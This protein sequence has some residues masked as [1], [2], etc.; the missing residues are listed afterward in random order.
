MRIFCRISSNRLVLQSHNF[1]KTKSKCEQHRNP[2]LNKFGDAIGGVLGA[3]CHDLWMNP[4]EVVKQRKQMKGSPYINKSYPHM[5][6]EIFRTEG[7]RAFYLSL[8][9]QLSMNATLGSTTPTRWKLTFAL[10]YSRT[11]PVLIVPFAFLQFGIY[12]IVKKHLNPRNEYSPGTNAVSGAVAGGVAAFIT[13]PLDV[14]KTVLN[15]QEN[16]T[17][18]NICNPC[19]RT[20]QPYVK[21]RDLGKQCRCPPGVHV[22]LEH[23]YIRPAWESLVGDRE[24]WL[25]CNANCIMQI[26]Y[27]VWEKIS[28]RGRKRRR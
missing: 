2:V 22:P 23:C 6:R 24:L 18:T 9:T 4:C 14:M 7:F 10:N 25:H 1:E 17:A 21:L 19:P 16:L 28:R 5:I 12:D 27:H 8:P 15:T 20:G 3:V 26:L 11:W 13:T